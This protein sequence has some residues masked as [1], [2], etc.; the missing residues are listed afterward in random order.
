MDKYELVLDIIGHPGNYTSEQLESILSDK[1]TREI[2]NLL[3][4][5]DSAVEA[6]KEID[7]DAEWENFLHKHNYRPRS[8]F[9]ALFG[10]RAA[11]IAIIISTSIIAIAAGLVFT[12]TLTERKAEPVDNSDVRTTSSVVAVA[13]DSIIAQTDS[14]KVDLT[15]IMFEDESLENIMKAVANRYGVEVK[16]NNREAALL[17]LYYKL[18]PALP[19]DDVVAQLNT[20]EQINITRKNKTLTID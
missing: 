14:A 7:V 8:K 12:V 13:A 6:G 19:L 16:F 11:S 9:F 15:P 5:T 4:K 2:Y 1:E 17:H 10:S 20:F 3:C 18:D